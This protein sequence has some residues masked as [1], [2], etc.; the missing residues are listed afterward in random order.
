MLR[1]D[2]L[3]V[4]FAF[5]VVVSGCIP[6]VNHRDN[7][8]QQVKAAPRVLLLLVGGNS[9]CSGKSGLW[10]IRE[11]VATDIASHL[12]VPR[13]RVSTDYVAW[14]GDPGDDS[15]CLPGTRQY[16][17]GHQAI[18]RRLS[19]Y[20]PPSSNDLL[21]VVGWSN[22]GATAAQLSEY[23]NGQDG[24]RPVSL[25]VTL[26]PVSRLT[27]RPKDSGAKTWLNVYTQSTGFDKL[28]SDNI[29]A[30]VGNA[31]DGFTGPKLIECMKGNHGEAERMWGAVVLPSAEFKDWTARARQMLG[32]VK[33]PP[34]QLQNLIYVSCRSPE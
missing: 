9:E 11:R 16:L 14:T 12:G 29:I 21:A 17:S 3:A 19:S 20:G 10:P 32:T 13:D 31:W 5:G 23:L 1:R 22:G 18:S 30:A 15:G 7:S 33:E 24:T 8:F 25:L 6:F 34:G 26:D 28:R 2:H 4:V 27:E